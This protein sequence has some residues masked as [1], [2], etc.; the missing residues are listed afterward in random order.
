MW[1]V[2]AIILTITRHENLYKNGVLR[3]NYTS[4]LL[5][6]GIQTTVKVEFSGHKMVNQHQG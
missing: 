5:M 3:S 4:S 2:L 6:V 1:G